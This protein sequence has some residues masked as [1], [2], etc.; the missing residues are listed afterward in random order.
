MYYVEEMGERFVSLGAGIV[1]R[2][3]FADKTVTGR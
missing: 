1:R 2:R 3:D